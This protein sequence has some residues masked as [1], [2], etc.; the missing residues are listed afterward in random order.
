M[1]APAMPSALGDNVTMRQQLQH[2]PPICGA[3]TLSSSFYASLADPFLATHLLSKDTSDQE[4]TPA[5]L[6]QSN[7][8]PPSFSPPKLIAPIGHPA[9]EPSPMPIDEDMQDHPSLFESPIPNTLSVERLNEKLSGTP[10]G[11]F[12]FLEPRLEEARELHNGQPGKQEYEQPHPIVDARASN[13]GDQSLHSSPNTSSAVSSLSSI[14]SMPS[15]FRSS[16]FLA[17]SIASSP[18]SAPEEWQQNAELDVDGEARMKWTGPEMVRD[19]DDRS[20]DGSDPSPDQSTSLPL[21]PFNESEPPMLVPIGDVSMTAE[22]TAGG[23]AFLQPMLLQEELSTLMQDNTPPM[24][25]RQIVSSEVKPQR[26]KKALTVATQ[27]SL[28]VTPA[29]SRPRRLKA[30]I[31]GRR[32]SEI[33][34]PSSSSER[35]TMGLEKPPVKRGTSS[36]GILQTHHLIVSDLALFDAPPV[37]RASSS[38]KAHSRTGS[39]ATDKIPTNRVTSRNHQHKRKSTHNHSGEDKASDAQASECDLCGSCTECE[40]HW[41]S[42]FRKHESTHGHIHSKPSAPNSPS[43]SKAAVA[44][45]QKKHEAAE[46][47]LI[48]PLLLPMHPPALPPLLSVTPHKASSAAV[49]A[50]HTKRHHATKSHAHQPEVHK[51]SLKPLHAIRTGPTMDDSPKHI[52]LALSPAF[53]SRRLHHKLLHGHAYEVAAIL[54]VRLREGKVWY[55]VAW[56]GVPD[57]FNSWEPTENLEKACLPLVEE[58]EEQRGKIEAGE[59]EGEGEVEMQEAEEHHEQLPPA[60]VM[61]NAVSDDEEASEVHQLAGESNSPRPT[62]FDRS[63]SIHARPSPPAKRWIQMQT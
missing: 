61:R 28:P 18:I 2:S 24:A 59:D 57:L 19:D 42:G 10:T 60:A 20:S 1:Q 63:A 45:Q 3:S 13:D 17:D 14:L 26:M 7:L 47:M 21:E 38:E 37:H 62:T 52:S 8:T 34:L 23:A 33:V 55:L 31:S 41:S 39:S 44:V 22:T 48:S 49:H 51:D 50:K 11:E 53:S 5:V 9:A 36:Q 15:P 35:G 29:S 58:F 25:T 27:R 12:V 4:H 56:K 32:N 40:K 30:G 46:D 43:S 16:S 54:D 6:A